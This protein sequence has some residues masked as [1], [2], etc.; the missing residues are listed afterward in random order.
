MS[1]HKALE[2]DQ[3]R[4][5]ETRRDGRRAALV[6]KKSCV[7]ACSPEPRFEPCH[8]TAGEA[9]RCHSQ[10]PDAP[11]PSFAAAQRS[12]VMGVPAAAKPA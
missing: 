12:V 6:G 2:K 4:I 1:D 10:T 7:T 5:R 9:R 11:A 8:P 3:E